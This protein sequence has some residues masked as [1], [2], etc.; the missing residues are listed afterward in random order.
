MQDTTIKFK[1]NSNTTKIETERLLAFLHYRN[2]FKGNSNTTKIE[3]WL[4][5]RFYSTLTCSKE[6]LIQQRL[7]PVKHTCWLC[8]NTFKGNSN[9]TKIETGKA[10]HRRLGYQ[11]FK[12]NSNT[13]K[14]ETIFKSK[15]YQFGFVQRKF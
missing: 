9:T 15:D 10:P 2:R 14:I 11:K 8:G 4:L 5:N 12:G 3:T 7:K 13:T 6:I 1:G